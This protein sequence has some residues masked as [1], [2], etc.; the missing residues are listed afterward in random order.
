MEQSVPKRQDAVKTPAEAF[1]RLV[2]EVF[3]LDGA[4]TA[5]GD[6]L[7]RPAGQTTA[8]WRILAAV[9]DQPRTVAE[10]A[11]AWSFARQSVQRI[12]DALADDGLVAYEDNPAHRRAKLVR[13]TPSGARALARIQKAQRAW[14]S[15]LGAR[16][17]AADLEAAAHTLARVLSALER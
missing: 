3:R 10:I 5:A 6:E 17:G 12:A 16:I 1:A 4:L 13:L 15:D 2:V 14:A 11:R 7:A 9:E 8:R